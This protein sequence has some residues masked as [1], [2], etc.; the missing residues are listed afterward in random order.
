MKIQLK[1]LFVA[2]LLACSYHFSLGQP[3]MASSLDAV[4]PGWTGKVFELSKSYPTTLPAATQPWKAFDFKT[5]QIQ[6]IN[7]V[8]QYVLEGNLSIDWVFK[9]NTVRKWYHTPA[10]VWGPNGR[11]FINGMTRERSSRPGELHPSQ[12]S[13][14]QNWAVGFYNP[15]GGYKIGKVYADPNHPA[16]AQAIFPEGTVAA[17]LLFTNATVAQVPYL[18]NAFTWQAN[19]HT[20]QSG[21]TS[22]SPATVR[23][24]QMDIAVKDN[25]AGS[26]TD[27][28]MITFAYHKDAPGATPW[29]RL[30]PVGL[31]WGN[32]PT[33]LAAGDP[34]T[35]TWINPAFK[36]LFTVGTWH[37]HTGY[38]GRFNGPV[39]NPKSAC[40]S[41]HGTAQDPSASTGMVPTTSAASIANYF[42]NINPPAVFE[43]LPAVTE[44]SL[45]YSL[46]L[47]VGIPLARSHASAINSF[48]NA[49]VDEAS[50]NAVEKFVMTTR[51]LEDEDFIMDSIN[52]SA[53]QK[54]LDTAA[55]DTTTAVGETNHA[56]PKPSSSKLIWYLL[57]GAAVLVAGII[58]F[59]RKKSDG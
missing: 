31:Q 6:Y 32:D 28:V 1:P 2:I 43:N 46:Q 24:L 42:R 23:L 29:D 27:W 47:S 50:K 7:A 37:M 56:T 48:R 15:R 59:T 12:T 53:S 21:T 19:I 30:V 4:P 52:N 10:M 16:A 41:C 14:F 44:R 17:K 51:D 33:H 18:A 57:A 13:F 45:D 34:L 22:R 35:E 49:H 5:Q 54:A 20:A 9:N 25:R 11:E 58:F 39:D 36:T 8:K 3:V 38:N 40:L 26:T 55:L